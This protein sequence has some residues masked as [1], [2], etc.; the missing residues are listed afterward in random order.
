MRFVALFML[1]L[2]WT[3]E[4]IA[5]DIK[6]GDIPPS[7]VGKSMGGDKI[8][9]SD[10]TGKVVVVTFWA[11]WCAP[12]MKELPVLDIIQ[13]QVSPNQLQVIA[14]NYGE[15]KKNVQFIQ[16]QLPDSNIVFTRSTMGYANRKFDIEGIPHM[17]IIDRQG[18]VHKINVGYGLDTAKELTYTLN[19]LLKQP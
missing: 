13:K 1:C 6:V 9:L 7:F 17:L 11:T 10:M 2:S 19:S 18:K 12:C 4:G 16:D 15:S 8:E 5:D 14:V 3:V